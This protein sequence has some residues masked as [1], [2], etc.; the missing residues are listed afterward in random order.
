[1]P[2]RV[3]KILVV[4]DDEN[5]CR[6][7]AVSLK[8]AGY[9]VTTTNNPLDAFEI[10]KDDAFDLI[11][12]DIKMPQ[13]NGIELMQRLKEFSPDNVVIFM[14]GFA[15]LDIAIK[16]VQEGAYNFIH[17]PFNLNEMILAVNNAIEKRQLMQENIRLKTL[18]NLYQ[19]SEQI[20]RTNEPFKLLESILSTCLLETRA[21]K[22]LI[23]FIDHELQE[24]YVRHSQ[25]IDKNE[26]HKIYIKKNEGVIGY[27]YHTQKSIIAN[28]LNEMDSP[29]P[30][31]IERRLGNN[32][33]AL[34][35]RNKN[36]KLGVLAIFRNGLRPFQITDRDFVKILTVQAGMA[37]DNADLVMD[38]EILFLETMKSLASA[39]DARDRYTL[40]HSRRVSA[41]AVA[42]GKQIQLTD[43][44]LEEIE[45]AGMLHDIGKI[46]IR[47]AILQK[48]SSLTKEEYEI[49]K[50]HPEKGFQILKHIK[51]LSTVVEAVYAHHEWYNGQGYPRGLAGNEIHI[52]SAILTIA[53]VFD[54]ITSERP[55]RRGSTFQQ[56]KEIIGKYSNTQFRPDLVDIFMTFSTDEIKY[57]IDQIQYAAYPPV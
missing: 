7:C 27:V 2:K 18:V 57:I 42:I 20:G 25:G 32:L 22:G 51:R 48:P 33:L 45:L 55:Y 56:A 17:K 24:I 31:E 8:N 28:K 54:A 29:K 37:F 12:T 49:I 52:Y 19:V 21:S 46:G 9:G 3:G 34:P 47:D 23:F 43:K 6:L 5:I 40:G 10:A 14:T 30:C 44:E 4:D 26:A 41:I 1:M 53:D 13:M 15:T 38:Q 36:K 50:T 35:I 16:A 39:L 11:L